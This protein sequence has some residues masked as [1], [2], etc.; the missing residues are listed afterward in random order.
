MAR[1]IIGVIAAALMAL[2]AC[3]SDS[4]TCAG[5][6]CDRA[7]QPEPHTATDDSEPEP[8]ANSDKLPPGK[9]VN[10]GIKP[11]KG[12]RPAPPSGLHQPQ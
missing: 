11:K 8:A 9:V 6:D 2:S 7:E 12:K 4:E 5:D 1:M 10:S 3:A